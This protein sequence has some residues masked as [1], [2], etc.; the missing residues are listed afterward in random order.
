MYYLY[1]TEGIFKTQAQIDNYINSKGTPI[2]IGEKRPQLGD[3]IYVDTDD[4]GNITDD[5]RQIVG[6]PWADVQ[7]SLMVNASW[8]N[9]DFSMMWYG[10]FGNDIY[11]VTNWQGTYFAD[12]S[13]YLNF[14]KGEEPYQVNPNSSSPRII[15]GDPR[16]AYASDRYLENGSF[17]RMKNIQLGYNF[18]KSLIQRFGIE[19]IRL[20]IAGNNLITLTGYSGLDP[21]FVNN[22]VWDRGTDS[23]AFPNMRSFMVGLDITF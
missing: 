8:K 17:F 20:Y 14:K 11:N 19:N 13:N 3:V 16:N 2:L 15:Y 7:L 23:F 12:N 5:D 4:N 22:D 9:F 18:D 21:D 1:K 6:D 10:Q